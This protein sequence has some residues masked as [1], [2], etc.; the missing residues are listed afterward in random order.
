MS[1]ENVEI[2]RQAYEAISRRDFASF[3][4]HAHPQIELHTAAQSPEAGLY[5]GKDAVVR[6]TEGM[7][8]PFESIRFE[9]E[10]LANASDRIAIVTTY[11]AVPRG[12]AQEMNRR[13]FEVW[14]VRDNL[15]AER[16]TYRTAAEAIEAVGLSQDAHTDS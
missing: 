6:Y 9:I 2:I 15:L 1:Q 5:R 3:N 11:Y 13:V 12:S 4:H 14:L 8:E 10:E 16:R 7:F